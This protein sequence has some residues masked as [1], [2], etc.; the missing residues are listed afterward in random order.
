MNSKYFRLNEIAWRNL[1][2]SAI[3][4]GLEQGVFDLTPEHD[5]L[6]DERLKEVV[7]YHY[8]FADQVPVHVR[9][10]SIGHGELTFEV[11]Y[12]WTPNGQQKLFGPT[13]A[14]RGDAFASGWLERKA[15]LWLQYTPSR[16]AFC[17]P[18]VTKIAA[19][20]ID[21]LGYADCGRF[22]Q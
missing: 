18:V 14:Y 22:Y 5:F 7:C 8:K 6:P 15:G 1:M 2:L 10:Y 4:A 17:A 19:V 16:F 12:N 20:D 21:P 13:M 11:D 3:N 9:V